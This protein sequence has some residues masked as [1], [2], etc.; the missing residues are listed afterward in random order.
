LLEQTFEFLGTIYLA[1]QV[2]QLG[3]RFQERPQCRHLLCDARGLEVLDRVELQVNRHFA[4]VLGQLVVHAHPQARGH[5]RH[6][7]VEVVAVDLDEL[8]FGKWAQWLRRIAGE[9]AQYADDERQFLKNF[10]AFRLHLVGDVHP[11]LA[12]TLKLVVDACTHGSFPIP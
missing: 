12:D 11:W 8:A 4:A 2:A 7:I 5:S 1:H 10:G 9:V 6:D 3:A